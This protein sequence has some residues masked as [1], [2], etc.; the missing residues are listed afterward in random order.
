[1]SFDAIIKALREGA[2]VRQAMAADDRARAA[3]LAARAEKH[4]DVAQCFDLLAD[5]LATGRLTKDQLRAIVTE[6]NSDAQAGPDV[7]DF[8]GHT[9]AQLNGTACLYC[10]AEFDTGEPNHPVALGPFGQMFMHSNPDHCTTDAEER[11]L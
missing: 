4:T 2:K 5:A 3:E 6:A 9:D 8:A 10:G 1:M 11:A 7:G